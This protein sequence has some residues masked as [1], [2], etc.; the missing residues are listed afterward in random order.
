M[1]DLP[2][3]CALNS[4]QIW[5]QNHTA[6]FSQFEVFGGLME[7]TDIPPLTPVLQWIVVVNSILKL[8]QVTKEI[9]QSVV[10]LLGDHMITV[11]VGQCSNNCLSTNMAV[12][13]P[14]L[15]L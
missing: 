6:D 10:D 1:L 3:T 8:H 9:L 7:A 2:L 11:S 13:N 15:T 12:G 4:I 14:F 5:R